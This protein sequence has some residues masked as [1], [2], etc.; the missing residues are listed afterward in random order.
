MLESPDI[1]LLGS[2]AAHHHGRAPGAASCPKRAQ[3]LPARSPTSIF[4]NNRHHQQYHCIASCPADAPSR[5]KW[6]AGTRKYPPPP[7]PLPLRPQRPA[8]TQPSK[9]L[10]S[11]IVTSRIRSLLIF[12]GPVL[13]PK[14]ISYYRSARSPKSSQIPIQPVP[15][16]IYYALVLL[17][18]MTLAF[19]LKTLPALAPENIFKL[20]S[21]RLQIPTDV[22]FNRVA[23]LRPNA[24]LT[25][26]DTVLRSKF[27]NLES[28]LLYLQFGPDTLAAC[29]FCHADD[30]N[31]YLYYAMPS[32]L[33][34]HM[35]NIIVV[36]MATTA[37]WTGRYGAQ[38]RT[39][40]TIAGF[41]IAGADVYFT[42]TY[43]YQA[44]ARALRLE[45]LDCFFWSSRNWRHIMLAAL[46]GLLAWV[47]YL[48]ATNR[49][50]LQLPSPAE[51]VESV[52]RGLNLARSKLSAVGIV[53][54]T[55]VRDEDLRLKSDSYWRREG[56]LMQEAME[57]REVVESVNDAL[58]NRISI[59]NITK[60]ADQ[61]TMG[62]LQST[63]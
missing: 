44:N 53:Q 6:S 25:A 2:L 27:I 11:N 7:Y 40:A 9:I 14:A 35:L 21:S 12:F 51:R 42:S 43:R 29:P 23:S 47:I 30:P 39:T 46:D 34:P 38:W 61:Y 54:N 48:S 1:A 28:R 10:S 19:L 60:D 13:I 4:T 26:A 22:L 58:E 36:A 59:E 50:F 31:A 8:G 45:D 41:V 18:G 17:S 32:I 24:A 33:W 56:A 3:W 37:V 16:R 52:N 63:E 49:A 57:E 55:M 62:L 5:P 20:T 15:A